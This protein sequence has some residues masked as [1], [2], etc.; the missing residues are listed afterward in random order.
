MEN[1]TQVVPETKAERELITKFICM[2]KHIGIKNNLFGGEMLSQIDIAGAIFAA[3]QIKSPSV[4]TKHISNVDFKNPVKVGHIV[5]FYGE[6]LKTGNTS[7]SIRISAVRHNVVTG[8]E[9][10]VCAVDMVFV[11]VDEE[12]EA[13]PIKM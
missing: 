8:R 7:I 12:G 5:Y 4:V 6:V 1:K 10:D 11:K 13:C 3:E 9:K 2:T